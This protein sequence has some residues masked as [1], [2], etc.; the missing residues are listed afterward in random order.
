M[1]HGLKGRKLN[2]TSSHRKALFQ[3]LVQA[4]VEHESIVTT[5]P[6]A[7]ELRPIVEKYVTMCRDSSLATRRIAL[8]RLQSEDTV[9][10]LIDNLSP[11]FQNRNGGYT[12]IIKNGFRKGDNAPMAIIQFVETD[13][14]SVTNVEKA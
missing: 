13:S 14:S 1:R 3:N 12:R 11:R 2:R 5:L 6:K 7:K 10:K 9:K 4:L 8:S